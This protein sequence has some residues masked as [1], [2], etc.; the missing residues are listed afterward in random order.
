MNAVN[1]LLLSIK[2]DLLDRR[3]LPLLILLAVALLAAVG[4]AVLGGGSS[5]STPSSSAP[6]AGASAARGGLAVTP[7]SGGPSTK[8]VAETTSGSSAQRKG[9]AHNPFLPLPGANAG[10]SSSGSKSGASSSSSSSSSAKGS[11]KSSSGSS[12]SSSSSGSSS[13]G[14]SSGG[15]KPST[16][17][18]SKPSQPA[19]PK[20][21]QVVYHVAVELGGAPAGTPPQ[22]IQMTPYENLKRLQ[23]LPATGEAPLVFAGVAAGGKRALFTLV[24]EVI[25]HGQATCSPSESQC[26]AIALAPGQVEELEYMPPGGQPINY[27]LQVVSITSSKASAA[28]AHRAYAAVSRRGRE[29][30]GR[31]GLAALPGELRYLPSKGVLVLAD[32]PAFGARAHSARH[33]R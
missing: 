24:H 25:L 20:P 17:A 21:P 15:S 14:S 3:R 23:P 2:A 5:S 8:A 22:S 10:T 9:L 19:K 28:S 31:N 16:P 11:G 33:S 27:R 32:H 6:G 12:S 1:E 7:S 4:Y 30:L 29:L 26:Q 13:S 18:P